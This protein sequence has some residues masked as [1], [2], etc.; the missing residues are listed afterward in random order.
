[1]TFE[2]WPISVVLLGHMS[3]KNP[4]RGVI[5]SLGLS[6]NLLRIVVIAVVVI[7]LL[8][9]GWTAYS[10]YQMGK[11]IPLQEVVRLVKEDQL[12]KIDIKEGT[13]LVERKD[14]TR[15]FTFTEP[16]T[17]FI[18]VLQRDEIKLADIK[19]EVITRTPV[20]IDWLSII[21]VILTLV[22][23]G[24]ILRFLQNMQQS[25]GNLLSF[26]KSKAGVII[27]KRPDIG[28]KDVAG[29][30]EAKEEISEIVEFLKNPKRFFDMGARIPKGVLLVGRPGTGKT[31]LAKAVAGEA[32][33]PFFHTSGAEF[34]EMLVGAGAARVRDLFK[35]AK[36]VA[37]AIIFIDEIDAV[38][39]KRGTDLRSSH[40]E[41]TLNQI[42]V[43]MDGFE[44]RTTVIVIAA[45]NRPDV[46]DPAILRPG[47]FDRT[48]TLAMPDRPEREE[49]LKV[50]A[51]NKK[52][53]SD[54]DLALIASQTIGFSGAD[55]ENLLNE[56]AIL[57]VRAGKNQ[58]TQEEVSEA[59]LK[60]RLGPKK[61]NRPITPEELR[62]IAYHESG[63]AIVSYFTPGSDPVEK[64]SITSRGMTGGVT[65]RTPATDRENYKLSEMVGRIRTAAAG[66]A[67]EELMYG[68]S[69]VSSGASGDIDTMTE[70][71][72]GMIKSYGM[73]KQ[74]GLVKYG[75]ENEEMYLGYHY[76]SG[77]YS[78]DTAAKIDEEIRT[79]IHE[80][81]Q[82]AMEILKREKV[83]L[84]KLTDKLLEE[85]TLDRKKFEAIM[86]KYRS[87]KSN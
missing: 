31:L 67:A 28:F 7:G 30:V 83:A 76:G 27:G 6:E 13:I 70:I 22:L 18:E 46:L 9:A 61:K 47:R 35:R 49:I 10:Q 81:Y 56:A 23:F 5:V 25:G 41:Q 37:P 44:K 87:D 69:E 8:F 48:I 17:S 29:S 65:I 51:K 26:G 75:A 62:S 53:A 11:E 40:S 33:V 57:A 84:E 86:S 78:Q 82:H 74:L 59:W 79:I 50:H 85:E 60:V 3:K 58:I 14:G 15:N 68:A 39:R 12:T 43:E 20:K 66:R 38:A 52:L 16:G 36:N 42:L 1:M 45:T 21:I 34:E 32:Q 55:L 71:A 64:I 72:R 24:S 19:A 73:S 80:E 63:H 4:E 2:L 54:V 77:D